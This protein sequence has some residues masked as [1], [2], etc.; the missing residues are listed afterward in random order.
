[1]S[2][3]QISPTPWSR[4]FKTIYDKHGNVVAEVAPTK[5]G[6]WTARDYANVQAIANLPHLLETVENFIDKLDSIRGMGTLKTE[7]L[8]DSEAVAELREAVRRIR[9]I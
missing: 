6:D 7:N 5:P 1:M 4:G 8:A 9:E 2:Q 3:D